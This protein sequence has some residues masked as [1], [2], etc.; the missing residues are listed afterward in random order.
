MGQYHKLANITKKQVIDPMTLQD[1]WKLLEFGQ[2]G[3]T[4]IALT[5]LLAVSNGRGG[6]DLNDIPLWGSW[7][8]DKIAVIGDYWESDEAEKTGYPTWEQMESEYTD[9]SID[10]MKA[11]IEGDTWLRGDLLRKAARSTQYSDFDWSGIFTKAELKAE[12]ERQNNERE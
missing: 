12:L 11:L 8:G 7:A 9:V 4:T 3:F 10:I 6:G 1:G 5:A 2:G